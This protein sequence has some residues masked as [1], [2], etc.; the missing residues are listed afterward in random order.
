M[1]SVL[2]LLALF[3]AVL[4]L[5]NSVP[6]AKLEDPA[7]ADVSAEGQKTVD[8]AAVS[9]ETKPAEGEAAKVEDAGETKPAE[10]ADKRPAGEE[11]GYEEGPDDYN[12]EE[13]LYAD[14]TEDLE[15]VKDARGVKKEHDAEYERYLA[16][17]RQ[18]LTNDHDKRARVIEAL[19]KM[20]QDA[21]DANSALKDREQTVLLIAR[22]IQEEEN[23]RTR[24]EEQ[25]RELIQS[26][27]RAALKEQLHEEGVEAKANDYDFKDINSQLF[28]EDKVDRSKI[29]EIAL[30]RAKQLGNID[31]DRRRAFIQHEIA[32]MRR[33]QK[34]IDEI[35]D[36]KMKAELIK[37]HEHD[38]EA[39]KKARGH[40]PGRKA[41]LEDEWEREGMD[42]EAFDPI[43]MFH[44]HDINGDDILDIKEL[45]AMFLYTAKKLHNNTDDLAIREEIARMRENLMETADTNKDAELDIKE[46]HVFT[47]TKQFDEDEEWKPVNPE[48]EITD[49]QKEAFEGLQK[50]LKNSKHQEL[51]PALM[52]QA[53]RMRKGLERAAAFKNAK[54]GF[55]APSVGRP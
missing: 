24:L 22:E 53:K 37:N 38:T 5:A 54:K 20:E 49:K 41:Q 3:L 51:D 10:E 4:Q 19:E 40:A 6:M 27:H 43:V 42:K 28:L 44:L 21:G 9:A 14:Q 11:D 29:L 26:Q 47:K 17:L 55:K 8:N 52:K 36:P 50:K 46:W 25:Q 31:H 23:A 30:E 33:L 32:R 39:L 35:S 7:A 48:E 12:D 16:E 1:R 15:D 13:R 2:F 34:Q 45:E 18:D